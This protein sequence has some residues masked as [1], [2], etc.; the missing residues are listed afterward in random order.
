MFV[1]ALMR[2]TA[3]MFWKFWWSSKLGGTYPASGL[4]RLENGRVS[5]KRFHQ[6]QIYL[7]YVTLLKSS[8]EIGT[9][10]VLKMSKIESMFYFK[11]NRNTCRE[12]TKN[13]EKRFRQE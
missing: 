1:L 8:F 7:E 2:I 9:H 11:E 6:K 3:A 13:F 4:F 12:V 5:P 10:P